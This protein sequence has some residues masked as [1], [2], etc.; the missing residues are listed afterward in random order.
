MA[1]GRRRGAHKAKVQ[2]LSLGDLVLAKVKG[3]PAWPAKISRPE[4][5]DREPDSKKYFVQFF[6]T[7]EIAFV[8][9]A[10]IQ[11]FSSETKNK[12]T[13][14]TQGK[15][16]YF[17]R[18]VEEICLAFE[19]LQ[20]EKSCG[21]RDDT[22]KSRRRCNVTSTDHVEDNEASKTEVGVKGGMVSARPNVETKTEGSLKGENDNEDLKPSVS[23]RSDDGLSPVIS[24]ERKRKISNGVRPK[25]VLSTSSLDDPSDAKD[26]VSPV[27][28]KT[29]SF[30][31]S[32]DP[33][34]DQEK[35]KVSQ[36][37]KKISAVSKRRSE[38][39]V[40]GQKNSKSVVTSLKDEK[41]DPEE[42]L[43]DGVKGKDSGSKIRSFSPGARKADLHKSSGSK[44][45][46]LVRTKRIPKASDVERDSLANSKGE[47]SGK[48][49]NG[50]PGVE[51]LKSR[52]D[53]ILHLAKKS[54]FVDIKSEVSR[55]SNGKSVN[56]NS[57]SSD[58]D[59]EAKVS[60]F[61]SVTS[62]VLA[63]RAS[64]AS[65]SDNSGDEVVLPPAKRH[66]KA[67]EAMLDSSDPKIGKCSRDVKSSTQF[68][69]EVKV[70]GAQLP[71]RR[72]AVCLYDDDDEDPKTP[73][74]GGSVRN[75]KE[76]SLNSDASKRP[77]SHHMVST[78]A[79][80]DVGDSVGFED[81]HQKEAALQAETGP[82]SPIPP[83]TGEGKPAATVSLS[84][85]RS[86]AEQ[87]SSKGAK[88]D[89]VS[90]KNTP[91]SAST[92]RP[93]IEQPKSTRAP[94][95][96]SS[97]G[98]QK[99]TQP[100]SAKGSVQRS[101]SLKSSQSQVS[102]QRNK[103]TASVDRPKSTPKEVSR[104]NDSGVPT[105]TFLGPYAVREDKND[106]LIDSK[107][108]DSATSM[109]H[110]IAAA[111]AKRKLAHSQQFA[112]GNTSSVYLS[113]SDV[114]GTSFSPSTAQPFFSASSN[115]VQSDVQ[116]LPHRTNLISP[117]NLSHQPAS[118]NQL[119]TE[120]IEERRASSGL[121]A[122]A[123]SLSG[124]TEAAVARDA[125]EGMIETL[126]RTKESIGRATRLAIDCAKYGIAN[127]VVELLI[128]K[129]GSEPDFGRKIDLFF[130]VDSITQC[131]HSQKGVA[132]SSYIPTVQ[133]A[134]PRLLAAAIPSG[135]GARENRRQCL[136]VL[137]LWLDRK[138]FPQSVLRRYMDD[139]GGSKNDIITGYSLRRPSRSERAID[140]PIREMEGMLVDEYGS[141]ATF[142]LPGFLPS[143][144]FEEDED[145]D[146]DFPSFPSKELSD[147]SPVEPDLTLDSETCVTPP[148]DRR[149]HILEDV[150][151]E[152]E[153][154]DVSGNL[155]EERSLTK[156]SMDLQHQG[157]DMLPEPASS[158][159]SEFPHLFEGSPPLPP[160]SPPPLPPL[161]SSPPP[162]PPPPAL[163]PSP[164]P[165]PP[166]PLTQPPH[167]PAPPSVSLSFAP[168]PSV[169]PQ[170]SLLTQSILPPQAP[171]KSSP[172]LAYQPPVPHEYPSTSTAHQIVQRV[173]ST[174]QGVHVDATGK[175][176]LF[177]QQSS[178]FG[179]MG[180]CTSREPSGYNS[181]RQLDYGRNDIYVNSQSSQPS[182]QFQPSNT[183]F[184]QRPLHPSLPQN[185]SAHFS[186]TKPVVPQHPQHPQHPYPSYSLAS[187]H[188]G[189]RQF[190][191]DE[192]WR[193][194]SADYNPDNQRG[195][196]V[197]GRNP[198]HAGPL[199]VQEGYFRPPAERPPP[200][201]MGFPINA[202][203]NLTAGP[204]SSG[205][206][207]SHILPCRPDMSTINCW[208]PG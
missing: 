201:N 30:D 70:P 2:D 51:R 187:Q 105:E 12:L 131:S 40:E 195:G 72:R 26:E 177:S 199:F 146:E 149:H 175:S 158:S 200:S 6:G 45:K 184:V 188:D 74:H 13:A 68:P 39:V 21:L 71:K 150:D 197:S 65:G 78:D 69:K 19:E 100:V 155:K 107:T 66:R 154:E 152:L 136:K 171:L 122:A 109:K 62:P 7:Q 47:T 84:P 77:D 35:N 179:P 160:D 153:M 8:A 156:T 145:E 16:K 113:M 18:A 85:K 14:K 42:Q 205:H 34:N 167:F 79:R 183:N 121:R 86:E 11:A 120:E 112:L 101:V 194:P 67:S 43:N 20:K 93:V 166:P 36:K 115:F 3:F 29:S 129:L 159:G 60:E 128:R 111:Q 57:F 54:K 189:L 180:V 87:L 88:E 174:S 95:R 173:G 162:P 143:I 164:P 169:T 82:L 168:H 97:N 27:K 178:C 139:L 15:T 135:S 144:A 90:P 161:P 190:G 5:W 134:L 56:N 116:M 23:G 127:E 1:G 147:A 58:N 92:K 191:T 32:K 102:A 125:F 176:E 207:V 63:L 73:V 76:L 204:S 33:S 119:E 110:L 96:D 196:W 138:I 91:Q 17:V 165:P 182:Q 140:D 25:T 81:G 181:S 31:H 192:K 53:K 157:T 94:T 133:A 130:L 59:K 202:A 103:L 142:Q 75:V 137:G 114:Q 193:M 55:G 198:S 49:K 141:N 46:D 123:G 24:F 37:S 50:E 185:P 98:T 117:L 89:L 9:P 186:F 148:N 22:D 64:K 124:G 132:G 38:D 4:D 61:K 108:S 163:F 104:I 44:G 41:A 118:Q 172:Q 208:R 206:V 10:D 126:S 83:Q 28:S 106:Y 52:T 151:G 99:K 170:S 80:P 203:N 48:K